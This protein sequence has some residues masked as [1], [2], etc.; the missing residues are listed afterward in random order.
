M[1]GMP[2]LGIILNRNLERGDESDC[3]RTH[4]DVAALIREEQNRLNIRQ[5]HIN[6]LDE[7]IRIK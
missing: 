5:S 6:M 2:A 3:D 4:L 1:D 7:S